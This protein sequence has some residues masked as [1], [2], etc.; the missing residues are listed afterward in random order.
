[1]QLSNGALSYWQG[2][3]SESWWGTIYS[4]HFLI[5]A[6]KAG[7]SVNQNMLS[8]MFGYMN[9]RLKTK[10][11]EFLYFTNGT[12]KEVIKTEVPYSLYVL[13]LAD[14]AK[15]SA[16]NYYKS[17]P[18]LLTQSGRYL[19][20]AAFALEGDKKKFYQM[21]PKSYVNEK[22]DPAFN[23]NFYSDFR[24]MAL[25][26]NTLLETDP[27]NVQINYMAKQVAQTL[28]N[29]KY[30]NTQENVF[31]FLAMG[32][33]AKA[34]NKGNVTASV[35]V[36]GRAV[37]AYDGKKDLVVPSKL[38]NANSA[39]IATSGNGKLFYFWEMEG[40]PTA[41]TNKEEDNFLEVRRKYF[42]RNEN[43]YNNIIYQNDLVVIEITIR[44]TNGLTVPNVAITDLLPAG[45]EI[46][47]ARITEIPQ[48]SWLKYGAQ[49]DYKDIRDDRINLIVTA[50]PKLERYYYLCR[51]TSL[52]IF[53]V[54]PVA[55]DAM[56]RG[57][58]HSYNGA[59]RI[60]IIKKPNS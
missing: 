49:P 14:E 8:K 31:G 26:L 27:Q 10:E 39:T 34:A 38:L 19:I 45:F 51:A 48:L 18:Q 7:Y 42:D 44:S 32:K 30:L 50:T 17:N 25:V 9:A 46:E 59:R 37:A 47:N 20:A 40:I 28:V 57:E 58:Y 60:S 21:L 53:N 36:N 54:G 5:E 13:A 24:D 3:G 41:G 15:T 4:A 29:R 16:L 11:L 6:Q 56:Y 35:S 33:L 1:M 52:G 12:K 55:A 23:G 22:T 2:Y 43:L